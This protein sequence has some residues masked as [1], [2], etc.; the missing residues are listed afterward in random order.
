MTEDKKKSFTLRISQANKSEMI[1]IL[2]EMLSEYVEDAKSAI[3]CGDRINIRENIRSARKC[4]EELIGSINFEY[5]PAGAL[6]RLYMYVNRELLKAERCKDR[7]CLDHVMKVIV[8][9]TNAYKE[10]AA[11][12]DSGPVMENTQTVVAGLTYGPGSISEDM[13]DSGGSRGFYV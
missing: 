3:D 12:D 11:G 2:Y 13:T 4:L 10:V 1:V 8:P 9:L 6:M 7:E 5:E